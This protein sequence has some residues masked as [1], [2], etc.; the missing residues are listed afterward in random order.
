MS[1]E[2]RWDRSEREFNES[3][4][5]FRFLS[6]DLG[7]N[8]EQIESLLV[9][10]GEHCSP[11]VNTR[12][13]RILRFMRAVYLYKKECEGASR[14]NDRFLKM[15]EQ[16]GNTP[17]PLLEKKELKALKD[18]ALNTFIERRRK[19]TR[20]RSMLPAPA[21]YIEIDE[22]SGWQGL[23]KELAFGERPGRARQIKELLEWGKFLAKVYNPRK[24]N[25]K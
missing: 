3:E 24:N 10:V 14:A 11:S 9:Q 4:E 1:K 12:R 5:H 25:P 2:P 6:E 7:L 18:S 17:P 8:D 21:R 23:I 16:G 19:V 13:K 22:A 15:M 20:G